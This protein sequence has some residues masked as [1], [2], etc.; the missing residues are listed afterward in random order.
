IGGPGRLT[1]AVT[2]KAKYSGGHVLQA[3]LINAEETAEYAA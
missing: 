2:G 1:C 3:T